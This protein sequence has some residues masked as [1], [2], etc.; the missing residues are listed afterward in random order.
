MNGEVR[1]LQVEP[2]TRCNFACG[3]CAGRHLPQRDMPLGTFEAILRLFPDISHLE[4]QGEGEPLLHSHFFD[5][6][7]L[8]RA[9]HPTARISTISNGSLF[10]AANVEQI[11]GGPLHKVY[12]SLESANAKLFSELRRGRLETVIDGIAALLAER[13]RRASEH[14]SVGLAVTV[15][16]RT[17]G[18]VPG[19]LRLYETLGLD[20]GVILQPLQ[21]MS[22]YTKHYDA[23]MRTELPSAGHFD[24]LKRILTQEPRLLDILRRPPKTAGFF[25][26]LYDGSKLAP[27]TCPWLAR[28]LYVSADGSIAS[29]C[30]QKDA[31]INCFGRIREV[32]AD[33]IVAKRLELAERLRQGRPSRGC[34]DCPVARKI[35]TDERKRAQRP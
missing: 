27:G 6:A 31:Q 26:E 14:P 9:V 22:G 21:S 30:F 4:L 23:A 13:R 1:F 17:T 20:G 11:V 33:E 15:L 28:G 7:R 24:D 12:V 18:E 10:S 16:Q 8:A 32:T 35:V 3:F 29:C 5:M 19:I 34:S 25:Q 2:T